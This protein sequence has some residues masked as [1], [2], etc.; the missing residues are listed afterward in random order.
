MR[1]GIKKMLMIV[2]VNILLFVAIIL[3]GKVNAQPNTGQSSPAMFSLDSFKP[4]IPIVL[5]DTQKKPV[6]DRNYIP[7]SLK[8]LSIDERKAT[9]TNQ[10]NGIVRVHGAVSSGYPKKSYRINLSN[11][12]QLL[13][14]KKNSQWVLNAAFIDR[15]LM[16]HK[17]SYD[18]FLKMGTK[19][20]PRYAAASR[21]VEVYLNDEYQGVYLLMERINR[22]LLNLRKSDTNDFSL[23]CIYKAVDHAAN[24]EQTGYNGYE[25]QEPD[26]EK[27]EYWKPLKDLNTFVATAKDN[28]FFN[29]TNGIESILDIENA[30]DF[31]LLVLLTSNSDGIT[32]NYILARNGQKTAVQTEKF[33]FAPWD[34]D[35]SFGRNWDGSVY[36]HDVWLSN[37]LYERLNQ[38]KEYRKRFAT[39]YNELRKTVFSEESLFQM[40]DENVKTLGDAV[41]RNKERWKN[42]D[43]YYPDKTTFEQ[44]IHHIKQ[45]LQKRL[46][47]LDEEMNRRASR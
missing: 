10:Y 6:L 37:H 14:L 33:F 23:S 5:I 8:I 1:C 28:V 44:D 22:K 36:P 35:G 7:C 38:N 3:T 45:W 4:D 16:R 41:K 31:H 40:I 47:W 15:S 34:Y 43:G 32:K 39:R 46:K 17:L 20:K 21:F 18:L 19:E 12:V 26:V 2:R 13:D 27:M 9:N 25:Q 42:T 29:P 24:F 30:I 11:D